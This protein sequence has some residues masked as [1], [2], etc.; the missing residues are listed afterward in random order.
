MAIANAIESTGVFFASS[1]DMC[2]KSEWPYH[3]PGMAEPAQSQ[4]LLCGDSHC[5]ADSPDPTF[6]W[7][8]QLVWHEGYTSHII[9]SCTHSWEGAIEDFMSAARMDCT[10][11]DWLRMTKV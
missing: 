1:C 4:A 3:F 6:T 2:V 10:I 7:G 8:P 9:V 5:T 11:Q